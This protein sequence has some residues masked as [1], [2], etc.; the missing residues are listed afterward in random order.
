VLPCFSGL[1]VLLRG[2][3]ALLVASALPAFADTDRIVRTVAL[4]PGRAL[5][6]EITVGHVRISGSTGPDA[7]IEIVRHAPS[8]EALARLPTYVFEDDLDVRIQAVQPEAATDPALRT[9]VTVTVP[10]N[11]LLRSIRIVEGRLAIAGLDGP[12][13]ADIRRGSIE[14]ADLTGSVRLE[15]GIG[16]IAVEQITVSPRSSLRLRTF[17]GDVTLTLNR[18]PTHARILVLALNGTIQSQIPLT[19]KDTWGPRWGEATLGA[20]E[21]VISI[22]VV[23]GRVEIRIASD[24]DV[25]RW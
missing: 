22:D 20:G 15:S 24:R 5:S 8:R 1:L 2:A 19:M 21:P 6:L 12:I 3:V 4:P 9:D 17:N 23:T 7:V 10:R 13:A 25:V 18:R 11:A 16:N 14:A